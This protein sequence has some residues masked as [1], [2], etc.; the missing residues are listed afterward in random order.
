MQN[1]FFK[2]NSA[3]AFLQGEGMENLCITQKVGNGA[4]M[5]TGDKGQ[6]ASQGAYLSQVFE[7][8]QFSTAV[9]SWN[10]DAPKGTYIEVFA[11]AG[12]DGG[13]MGEWFSWGQWGLHHPRQSTSKSV[14]EFT[15]SVANRVQLKAVLH[16]NDP[17]A[18]PVLRLLAITMKG[19]GVR[20]AKPEFAVPNAPYNMLISGI[21]PYSQIIRDKAPDINVPAWRF[22]GEGKAAELSSVLPAGEAAEYNTWSIGGSICSLT[23]ICGLINSKGEDVLPEEL[24]LSAQDFA[25]G[26]GN[27]PYSTAAAA[28]YGYEAYV[29]YANYDV[30]KSEIAAGYPVGISVRYSNDPQNDRYVEGTP[31]TT[32]GH[33]LLIRGIQTID[34]EDWLWVNDSAF[35]QG[36]DVCFTKYRADQLL[37]PK[38][39]SSGVIYVV[40]DKVAGAGTAPIARIEATLQP[41]GA[42]SKRYGTEYQLVTPEGHIE[43]PPYYHS[44]YYDNNEKKY[45]FKMNAPGAG[46][47]IAYTLDGAQGEDSPF[48]T[49][50]SKPFYYTVASETGGVYINEA[51]LSESKQEKPLLLTLY[52]LGND[53][54]GYVAKKVY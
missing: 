2:I 9:A 32:S 33:L 29:R 27:W 28:A 10:C 8:P 46:G 12:K 43:L 49:T 4:L 25:Y 41:T 45:S 37:S 50:A 38:V 48:K 42:V 18:S 52:V 21:E 34:G 5:L 30:I 44:G 13:A 54:T 51:F 23:T 11:R 31:M 14:D 6:Y 20:D 3:Q 36:N 1:N 19:D 53:G 16:T 24:A 22:D 7:V 17:L 47:V 40:H 39:W 15:T 26:F 35:K